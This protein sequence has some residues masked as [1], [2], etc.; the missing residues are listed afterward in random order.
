[1]STKPKR[2]YNGILSRVFHPWA[3]RRR[4]KVLCWRRGRV[5]EAL[6]DLSLQLVPEL[7]V[8][9]EYVQRTMW[10]E[11]SDNKNA[12]TR[13]V[14]VHFALLNRVMRHMAAI[15][16]ISIEDGKFHA[17]P[18]SNGLAEDNYQRTIE[19]CYDVARPSFNGM[20]EYWKQTDYKQ[21]TSLIDGPYTPVSRRIRLLHVRLPRRQIQLVRSKLLPRRLTTNRR[22][23]P[24]D[25][26]R[27]P[28]QRGHDLV[29]LAAQYPR[30]P[31]KLILQ[32]RAPVI[33]SIETTS[34][35]TT[36]FSP[37][38]HDFFTPQ[39]IT[40]ARAYSLHSIPHDCDDEGASRILENLKP[41]LKM[42][43]FA[44]AV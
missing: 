31:G 6:I 17:T 34:T 14:V 1:M 44:R 39:P 20:P 25:Q 5:P 15:H 35:P 4:R 33:A 21:P 9:S 2:P 27:S 43:I 23:R 24:G 41:A 30:H 26:R 28:R 10:A 42:G 13:L 40:H 19:F 8:P 18:L 37:T 3:H 22:L 32:G 12:S 29:Q 36:P 38:V 16:M 7:E 11:E